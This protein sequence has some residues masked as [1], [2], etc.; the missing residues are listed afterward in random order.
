MTDLEVIAKAAGTDLAT[1]QDLNPQLL[2][3]TTPNTGAYTLRVPE[4]T[5]TVFRR[6]YAAI[7]VN[8]R[9]RILE[10]RIRNGETLSTIAGKYGISV[11]AISDLN[12]IRNRHRIRAGHTLLIPAGQATATRARAA[13]SRDVVQGQGHA[14]GEK[15][16]HTVKK[17]ESLWLIARA[18]DTTIADIKSWNSLTSDRLYR[19]D[20]L[21]IYYDTRGPVR[22]PVS[23]AATPV[24]EA[25]RTPVANAAPTPRPTPASSDP[26]PLQYTVQRGDTLYDIARLYGVTSADIKRWNNLRTSRIYPGKRLAIYT[27]AGGG[28]PASTYTIRRGDTLSRIAQRFGVSVGELCAWNAISART[29]LYPGNRLVIRTAEAGSGAR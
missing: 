13:V 25:T 18:Y 21:E 16:V 19:G 28:E 10:H 5:A 2:R 4:G 8:E 14:R 22:G 29:T 12:G 11:A 3:R 26:T 27:R 7:P 24:L 20:K 6:A 23:V 1:I 17:G 15:V 9:V